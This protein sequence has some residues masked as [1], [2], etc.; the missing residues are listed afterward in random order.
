[1]SVHKEREGEFAKIVKQA[2]REQCVPQYGVKYQK[3]ALDMEIAARIMTNEIL[4]YEIGE[5]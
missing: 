4:K 2:K 5:T 1:M 3:A